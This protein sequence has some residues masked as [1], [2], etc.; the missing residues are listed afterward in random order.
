MGLFL[1]WTLIIVP[2]PGNS[3]LTSVYRKPTHTDLY[4]HCNS[5]HH[6]SARF[7]VINNP[8]TQGQD[9][10]FQPDATEEG[11]RPPEQSTEKMQIPR[12]GPNQSQHQSE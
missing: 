6:L 1:S 5:H 3:L 9:S 10:L 8:Q 2:Q 7:S 12:V 11:R 4:L